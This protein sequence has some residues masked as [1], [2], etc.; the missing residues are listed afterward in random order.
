M[1]YFVRR[2]GQGIVTLFATITLTF[3]LYRLLPGSPVQAMKAHLL[4]QARRR[5]G[6]VNMER[7]NQ[8]VE[9]Y[10]NIDPS[11]PIWL[12]YFEYIRDIVLYLDF[13][14]SLW[15]SQPV[16]DI[17][18]TAMP[19]S[20][21]VSVYGLLF[22]FTTSIILGG[23]M[24]YAE[25][26]RFDSVATVFVTVMTSIPY[27]IVAILMLS[28]LAFQWGLFPTGGRYADTVTPGFNLPFIISVIRHGAL[29][30]LTGYVVGF[31]GGALAMR[32]NS[33]RVIGEDYIRV[34]RLRGLSDNRIATR[35][36]ARVA[37]LPMYTGFMIGISGIFSSSVIME[38]I[39]NY[40]GVGWYTFAALET[41]DYPLLMGSLIFYTTITV[42]GILMAD[43]TYSLLDPRAKSGSERESY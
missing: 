26:S 37:I 2:V 6:S 7:I 11:K 23:L 17:L 33:L 12:A 4:E 13:G 28:F 3:M 15:Y 35:Y 31:G 39:F 25:G 21:F 10:T 19:W 22:G 24:A 34:A 40:P 18:F 27:Y 9:V 30:I 1:K 32:G 8:L 42:A 36:V 14:V 20:V 43:L 16:F 38:K 41:Q 5:G 29:P